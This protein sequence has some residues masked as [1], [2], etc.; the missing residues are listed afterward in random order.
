MKTRTGFILTTFAVLTLICLAGI[1]SAQTGNTTDTLPTTTATAE[2][3]AT[4]TIATNETTAIPTTTGTPVTN[5]TTT[6][7]TTT[8]TVVP[9]TTAT[10]AVPTTIATIVPTATETPA[11]PVDDSINPYDGPI[12]ADNPLYGLKLTFENLDE[13]FTSNQTE[14]MNKQLNH[15]RLRLS[16]VRKELILNRSDSAQRTLDLYWQKVN[17]TETYLSLFSSN[18]TGLLH[19]QEQIA[20]HG[21][22]LENLMLANPNNT[23]L[24]RAYN[25]SLA[26]EERFAGKTEIKFDRIMEKNNKTILK[27]I[28]METRKQDRIGTQ[29]VTPGPT[30]NVTESEHV[31]VDQTKDNSGKNGKKNAPEITTAALTRK[32]TPDQKGGG[33]SGD[34]GKGNPHK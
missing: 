18:D 6:I 12:D 28:R 3:T 20:K 27:A 10:T 33:N 7:P 19:A 29:P 26:L 8:V 32:P 16:E 5:A 30:G 21:L 2:P 24:M 22:I 17:L 31:S 15:A 23:G 4:T 13:S 34:S 9:N 14:R 25:N 1:A 11:E